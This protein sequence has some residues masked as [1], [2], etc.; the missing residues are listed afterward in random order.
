MSRIQGHLLTHS[1]H[2]CGWLYIK[3]DYD[4]STQII[5]ADIASETDPDVVYGLECDAL[6]G[7]M[8]CPCLDCFYRRKSKKGR[9]EFGTYAEH[10]ARLKG[11]TL[12]PLISRPPRGFCKHLRKFRSALM[13]RGLMPIFAKIEERLIAR[14][15]AMDDARE[16]VAA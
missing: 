10:L 5:T 6:T 16:E 3:T 8:V 14:L 2:S 13:R 15:E 7:E 9:E 11:K 12:L 1:T 4:S